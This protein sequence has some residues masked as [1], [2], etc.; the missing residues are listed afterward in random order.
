MEKIAK[1]L[2]KNKVKEKI[3]QIYLKAAKKESVDI[4][5]NKLTKKKLK[6]NESN[7]H[8]GKDITN[9]IKNSAQING[10]KVS[11]KKYSSFS[12]NVINRFIISII[13]I[14]Q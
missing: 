13:I 7:R 5:P 4:K 14:G 11:R 3:P 12:K 10:L 9:S 1:S 8:F 2:S 6:F